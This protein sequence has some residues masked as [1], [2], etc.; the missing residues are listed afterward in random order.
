MFLRIDMIIPSCG[1][2]I[3]HSRGGLALLLLFT[4][5]AR[6][7]TMRGLGRFMVGPRGIHPWHRNSH[8]DNQRN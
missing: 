8:P 2:I 4:F 1:S 7:T 3:Q 5:A 6:I